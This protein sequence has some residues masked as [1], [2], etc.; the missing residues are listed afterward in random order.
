MPITPPKSYPFDVSCDEEGIT[1]LEAIL[2][3]ADTLAVV[4]LVEAV[5][6]AAEALQEDF[7]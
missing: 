2:L 4:I 1:G 5:H 6:Q 3:E 7:N